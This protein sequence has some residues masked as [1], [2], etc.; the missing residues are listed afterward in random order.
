DSVREASFQ[1]SN[2]DPE[3]GRSGGA[4]VNIITKSGSNDF[5][6]TLSYL[7]DSRRDDAITSSESRNPA[8]TANGLPFGIENIYS[9]SLGGP[10]RRNQ[11]FFFT[12]YQEDRKRAN[13]QMQLI[14]PTAAGRASL[15]QVYP[16]GS[17][18][19]ADLYLSATENTVAVA[20]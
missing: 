19:N 3:Y 17:S 6:G 12:S 2:F 8:I 13:P 9:F 18:S 5:H 1:S 14:V 7:L 11:T 10:I 16:A 4:V 20:S 15:R